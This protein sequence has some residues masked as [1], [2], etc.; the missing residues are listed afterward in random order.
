MN[1]KNNELKKVIMG[2]FAHVQ[3]VFEEDD[4]IKVLASLLE[5]VFCVYRKRDCP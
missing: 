5:P 2:A 4:I 3:Q 1:L